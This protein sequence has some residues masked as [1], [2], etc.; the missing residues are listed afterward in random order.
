MVGAWA[1]FCLWWPLSRLRL[2]LAG[3]DDPEL[4]R[5]L[6]R[7]LVWLVIFTGGAGFAFVLGVE[8]TRQRGATV[9]SGIVYFG[10]AAALILIS[11][12]IWAYSATIVRRARRDRERDPRVCRGIVRTILLAADGGWP[13]LLRTDRGRNLWLTGSPESLKTAT[14]RLTT[15]VRGRP[16]QLV[17]VVTYYPRC[18]VIREVTGMAVESLERAMVELS[19]AA[20]DHG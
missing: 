10:C 16:F 19:Q 5:L 8:M 9:W 7:R 14:G 12:G 11:L 20:L 1:G 3:V 18:R 17:I 2:C 13:V 6:T 15:H 4:K